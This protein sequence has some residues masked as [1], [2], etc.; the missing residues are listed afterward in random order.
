MHMPSGGR[1]NEG[2]EGAD[3]QGTLSTKPRVLAS[4][5]KALRNHSRS[6]MAKDMALNQKPLRNGNLGLR[7]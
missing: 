1:Q 5:L 4:L 3:H 7:S 6:Q 2:R